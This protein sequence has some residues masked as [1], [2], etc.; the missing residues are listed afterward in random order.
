MTE[1]QY[2]IW[3]QLHRRF[4]KGEVLSEIELREY[5]KGRKELETE[6]QGEQRGM[7]PGISLWQERWQEL[8]RRAQKLAQQD[9]NLRQQATLL[10]DQ[11]LA[12]T[13]EKL[14]LEA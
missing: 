7:L 4:A 14:C 9:A 13:G 2:Q 6:E 10:E 8:G 1:Q 12:L 11:Y 3:W 5:K